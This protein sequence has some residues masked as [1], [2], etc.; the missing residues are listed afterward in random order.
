MNIEHSKLPP[1][2]DL[3][4][5]ARDGDPYLAYAKLRD[6]GALLRAGPGVWVIP[7]Y[8]EVAAL[9]R[10]PRLGPFRFQEAPGLFEHAALPSSPETGVANSFLDGIMVVANSPDHARLRQSV[11]QPFLHRLNRELRGR[12]SVLADNLLER[13]GERGMMEVISELA[14]PLPLLVLSD[15]F[16]IP[17]THRER[18]GR[19]VLKLSKLFSPVVAVEDKSA[20][21]EAI[22]SLRQLM[23]LLFEQRLKSPSQDF[24]SDMAA[25]AQSRRLS[26]E[27]AID[28]TIFLIFAGLE[29]SISLLAAGCAALARYPEQMSKLRENPACVSTAVEEFL[30]YDAPTQITARTVRAPL[31]VAGRMLSKGRVLLLL[32]GSANHDERQFRDPA[33][34]D[35]ER[36]PNPHLAFG[37]GAHY[38]LG[39]G[40]ARLESEV[41]F[42][43]LARKFS[44]FESVGDVVR[45]ACVTPRVYSSV[46]VRVKA[47]S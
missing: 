32:L 11:G 19:E 34:L 18:I 31:E 36:T 16:G 17:Q 37:A 9:L 43:R 27:E 14:Y 20:A 45:E 25:A 6:A 35:V 47:G 15:I 21:D 4:E 1:K 23:G 41:V 29:T 24:I 42:N 33:R 26:R 5:L 44:V 12:I 39:A 7:R 10:D 40:L 3:F 28:N 8:Q 2:F 38:C 13:A 30:R 46:V 22:V